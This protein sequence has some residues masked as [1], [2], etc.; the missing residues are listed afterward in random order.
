MS[1]HIAVKEVGLQEAG[2]RMELGLSYP[3]RASSSTQ[4]KRAAVTRLTSCPGLGTPKQKSSLL[5]PAE[6]LG[7]SLIG[8]FGSHA[9]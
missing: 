2:P 3:C 8:W 1:C 6:R 7:K 5:V 4:C 9:L